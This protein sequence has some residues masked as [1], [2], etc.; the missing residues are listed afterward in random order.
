V[1]CAAS[2]GAVVAGID[3]NHGSSRARSRDA[4]VVAGDGDYAGKQPA[5]GPVPAA[6]SYGNGRL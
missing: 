2:A 5:D 1:V 6:Y 3:L 4:V